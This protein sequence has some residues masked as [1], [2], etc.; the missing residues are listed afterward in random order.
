MPIHWWRAIVPSLPTH[1]GHAKVSLGN[2][3][4]PIQWL[5][6]LLSVAMRKYQLVAN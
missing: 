3:L 5:A 2:P 1:S 4:S 6:A